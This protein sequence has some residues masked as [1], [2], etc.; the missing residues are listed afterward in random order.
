MNDIVISFC[1]S[2]SLFGIRKFQHV[3]RICSAVK[4]WRKSFINQ[5]NI[6]SPTF[7][8][9]SCFPFSAYPMKSKM[10]DWEIVFI[11]LSFFPTQALY[12]L[13]LNYSISIYTKIQSY[14]IKKIDTD[15][16]LQFSFIF[17]INNFYLLT[18][19]KC[20]NKYIRTLEFNH[21]GRT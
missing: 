3:H 18:I 17:M 20:I 11:Y 4:N 13:I 19:P 2:Q 5:E 12:S 16:F 14:K 7:G 10:V 21:R 8:F 1:L 15:F 6:V 9:L